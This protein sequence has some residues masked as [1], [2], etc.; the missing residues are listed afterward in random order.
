MSG[1][2]FGRLEAELTAREKS[3]GL[4]MSDVLDMPD[5]QRQLINWLL[6][7]RIADLAQVAHFLDCDE[8]A[9][10]ETLAGLVEGGLVR[11]FEQRGTLR[12][13]VRLAPKRGRTMPENLWQALDDKVEE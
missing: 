9:V 1:G 10:R 13:Q 3:P 11:E 4:T 5:G 6:R 8:A 12:Y 2:L 7:Q